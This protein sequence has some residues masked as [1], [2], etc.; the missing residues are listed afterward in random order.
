MRPERVRPLTRVLLLVGLP[1]WL[2]SRVAELSGVPMPGP[3]DALEQTLQAGVFAWLVA[4][5]AA[6]FSGWS[7]WILQSPPMTYLGRISYGVYLAHGFAGV[8]VAGLL[9]PLGFRMP[10]PEP[11]RLL[12]LT[13]VTLAAASLSWFLLERPLNALKANFPYRAESPVESAQIPALAATDQ[14]LPRD[15]G[16]TV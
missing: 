14:G 9:G 11:F 12:A 2:L 3:V 1:G 15:A 13:A 6:G 10:L 5:A 7:G 16:V 4:S 8:M